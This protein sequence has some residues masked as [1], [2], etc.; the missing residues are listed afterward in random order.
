ML[1][2]CC[3]LCSGIG[4]VNAIEVVNA[5]PEDDGLQK[6][7]E[8]LESPDPAILGRL[9]THSRKKNS[10]GNHID[11]DVPTQDAQTSSPESSGFTD[12]KTS[13]NI[14][15]DKRI[16]MDKHVILHS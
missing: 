1:I 16:F 11:A 13:D 6:F 10:K 14:S 15:D 2:T 8:W 4:I 5:F 3:H 9:N 12:S 7:R